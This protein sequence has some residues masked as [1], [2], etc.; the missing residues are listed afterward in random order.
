MPY[1]IRPELDN[2]QPGG[3][4]KLEWPKSNAV[5]SRSPRA[6]AALSHSLSVVMGV[7][8]LPLSMR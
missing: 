4:Y 3:P 7:A 1:R 8:Q 6:V 5:V 2:T